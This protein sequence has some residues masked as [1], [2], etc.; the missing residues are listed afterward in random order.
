MNEEHRSV[1]SPQTNA[2]RLTAISLPVAERQG[3]HLPALAP[4]SSL[5]LVVLG[6][7]LE[8]ADPLL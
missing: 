3:Y 1:E 7:L 8:V 4:P 2:I 5:D 6:Q